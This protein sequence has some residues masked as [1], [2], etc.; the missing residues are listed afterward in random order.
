MPPRR[1]RL[2]QQERRTRHVASILDS[3]INR[4]VNIGENFPPLTSTRDGRR[5]GAQVNLPPQPNP[6]S[7]E[8]L[9][10]LLENN[11]EYRETI[12]RGRTNAPANT[13]ITTDTSQTPREALLLDFEY[14]ARRLNFPENFIILGK[15]KMNETR[16]ADFHEENVRDHPIR[17]IGYKYLHIN[18]KHINQGNSTV[19]IDL[20]LTTP[21]TNVKRIAL[22]SFSTPNTGF[23]IHPNHKIQWLESDTVSGD[24]ALFEAELTAG[25]YNNTDLVAHITS[26]MNLVNRSLPSISYS[27]GGFNLTFQDDPAL[28]NPYYVNMNYTPKGVTNSTLFYPSYIQ[29][30]SQPNVWEMLGFDQ[31]QMVLTNGFIGAKTSSD[32]LKP[33]TNDMVGKAGTGTTLDYTANTVSTA[34]NTMGL[35]IT[36]DLTDNAAYETHLH[37]GKNSMSQTNILEWVMN[38]APVYSYLHYKPENPCWH[39]LHQPSITHFNMKMLDLNGIPIHPSC[40]R[41]W[42]MVIQVEVEEEIDYHAEVT[43][44]LAA[45]AWRENHQ[46]KRIY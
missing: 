18:S 44:K 34:A 6:R 26:K 40:L 41:N 45:Q 15:D 27:A 16:V 29:N 33:F 20:Y 35:F 11:V 25:Y 43:K 38:D 28:P 1:P 2:T 3:L 46:G 17:P 39:T 14:E 32:I 30:P 13:P 21:I 31:T 7:L 4:A 23:N 5:P 19:N 10:Y 24:M 12:R 9:I 36:T 22:K 8:E 37:M 42:Q